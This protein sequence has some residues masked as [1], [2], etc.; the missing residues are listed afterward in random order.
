MGL[1]LYCRQF[2]AWKMRQRSLIQ[3][4]AC[5]KWYYYTA[6]AVYLSDYLHVSAL[7]LFLL[8][9]SRFLQ[10]MDSISK[11]DVDIWRELYSSILVS[12]IG[13]PDYK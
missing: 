4:L 8:I 7:A 1:L 9:H 10:V 13:F 3:F 11:C 6:F 5:H 12:Y 2:L